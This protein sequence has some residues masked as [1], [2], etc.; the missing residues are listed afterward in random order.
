MFNIE[1]ESKN[2]DTS[3]FDP[4]A[5][6]KTFAEIVADERIHSDKTDESHGKR[7][8]RSDRI[9]GRKS[10]KRDYKKASNYSFGGPL[11]YEPFDENA[12]TTI[13]LVTKKPKFKKHTNATHDP[14]ARYRTRIFPFLNQQYSVKAGG[15]GPT[16]SPRQANES[17]VQTDGP[18]VQPHI[19]TL[20]S[21]ASTVQPDKSTVQPHTS[22]VQSDKSTVQPVT[23]TLQSDTSTVLD[24]STVQP[25]RKRRNVNPSSPKANNQPPNA[26]NQPPKAN[27]PSPNANNSC[28]KAVNPSQNAANPSVA[29]NATTL[30][31]A[32]KDAAIKRAKKEA[33]KCALMLAKYQEAH[34]KEMREAEHFNSHEHEPFYLQ[35]TITP[36][37]TVWSWEATETGEEEVLG[38]DS[39][40]NKTLDE[41]FDMVNQSGELWWR[42]KNLST[43]PVDLRYE[44]FSPFRPP[45]GPDGRFLDNWVM[46]LADGRTF[47]RP[48]T[49][50]TVRTTPE[51]KYYYSTE[52]SIESLR[53][54]REAYDAMPHMRE[55]LIAT[56]GGNEELLNPD[57]GDDIASRYF[58][59][60]ATTI[61]DDELWYRAASTVPNFRFPKEIKQFSPN[62]LSNGE[63]EKNWYQ[64]VD[65]KKF[66]RPVN[67]DVYYSIPTTR[68]VLT[69][70]TTLRRRIT[71]NRM[72]DA[73]YDE[74]ARRF[75]Q[76]MGYDDAEALVERGEE[77]RGNGKRR[78]KR[79]NDMAK[80]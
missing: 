30:S 58:F 64:V 6:P 13:K 7:K 63:F 35:R 23:S 34:E 52:I 72:N 75:C 45:V 29:G 78:R 74:K 77:K 36:K 41:R 11:S 69:R 21:D 50:P 25:A 15:D 70:T 19:S 65:G 46:K 57:M 62:T 16:V 3:R 60:W 2:D 56:V 51:V 28:A 43:V 39:W 1:Q 5:I 68:Q 10:T 66:R 14:L 76:L 32:E 42:L 8:D 54:L 4:D 12:V 79:D 55:Q 37:I 17:A 26:N 27:N 20:Q 40:E 67:L 59:S 22:T 80:G 44:A 18:T 38:Y 33:K 61:V 9:K 47:D 24:Q 53:L 31:R 71:D 48:V 73:V 49:V